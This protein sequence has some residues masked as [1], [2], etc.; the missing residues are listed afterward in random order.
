[1]ETF[2]TTATMLAV[3]EV[4]RSELKVGVLKGQ[5][6][7]RMFMKSIFSYYNCRL[8]L[9]AKTVLSVIVTAVVAILIGSFYVNW[10]E[11]DWKRKWMHLASE[12][13]SAR[14]EHNRSYE[15]REYES[16]DF[17]RLIARFQANAH[18]NV[19]HLIYEG[20]EDGFDFFTQYISTATYRMKVREN[21]ALKI[22]RVPLRNTHGVSIPLRL[23][24]SGTRLVSEVSTDE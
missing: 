1:M 20:T 3:M 12:L 6:V 7:D 13:D 4:T 17:K 18:D 16:V 24:E 9:H 22:G 19:N 23:D 11:R 15:G 14:Q 8:R 21:P 10:R 2:S 5:S